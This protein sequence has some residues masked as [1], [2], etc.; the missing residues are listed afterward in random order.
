MS[1]SLVRVH[2]VKN[3]VDYINMQYSQK[4]CLVSFLEPQKVG[5]GFDMSEWPLHITLADVFAIDREESRIDEKLRDLLAEQPAVTIT[6]INEAT[7]GTIPVVLV[8]KTDELTSL[9]YCILDLLLSNGAIFNTPAFT[10]DGFLP[11][12][13]IQRSGR[14]QPGDVDSIRTISLVD[15][16]PDDNW[17]HRKV[18]GV[19]LLASK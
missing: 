1:H 17:Q 14:L 15:M 8:E 16:F 12:S 10:G 13:T 11:H 5:D 7:L 19:Y 4:Y 18:L 3:S 6:A 2:H 9:H